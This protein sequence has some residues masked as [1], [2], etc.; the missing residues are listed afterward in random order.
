MTD[1]NDAFHL[2][3]YDVIQAMVTY[4]GSFVS[5][6]G[7]AYQAADSENVAR[8]KAAFPEYW[9]TYTKAA[10]AKKRQQGEAE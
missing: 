2:T 5:A 1:A 7:K 6:L 9:A 3:D 4:G 10:I 8:L